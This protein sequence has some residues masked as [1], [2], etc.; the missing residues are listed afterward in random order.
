MIRRLLFPVCLLAV[1]AATPAQAAT[2]RLRTFSSC[3]ALVR[4]AQ[5]HTRA[6]RP[7]ALP[8]AG[9]PAIG[10]ATAP[11]AAG[12]EKTQDAS[13]TNVQEAGVDEPDVVKSD[14]R[15]LL[16]IS[17]GVLYAIDARAATPTL[18]GSLAL[19][20]GYGHE[21]LVHDGRALVISQ[22]SPE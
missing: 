8:S 13:T 7:L 15:H 1:F 20:E 9:G 4:Y 3:T 14:G 17:N 6:I 22:A 5:H 19:P 11:T 12:Q 16:A 2:K 18:A 21:L 10:P